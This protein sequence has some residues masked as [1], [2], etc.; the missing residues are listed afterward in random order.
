MT[1]C[2]PDALCLSSLAPNSAR[3]EAVIGRREADS[4]RAHRPEAMGTTRVAAVR[5]MTATSRSEVLGASLCTALYRSPCSVRCCTDLHD[6][7]WSVVP[8]RNLVYLS[9]H[10]YV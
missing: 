10:A 1:R 6:V 4:H 5:C 9:A 2:D 7:A 3:F 8:A